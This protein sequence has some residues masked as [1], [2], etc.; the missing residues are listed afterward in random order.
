VR[1]LGRSYKAYL[2]VKAGL[3]AGWFTPPREWFTGLSDEAF[4]LVVRE[5]VWVAHLLFH[6]AWLAYAAALTKAPDAAPGIA[7][8][9]IRVAAEAARR[10]DWPLLDLGQ[11]FANTFLRE[12]VKR[13]DA[14]VVRDVARAY[15]DVL[16]RLC[17][18]GRAQAFQAVEKA[19]DHLRY[20][21]EFAW[22]TGASE[23][24]E[25][26]AGELSRVVELAAVEAPGSLPAVAAAFEDLRVPAGVDRRAL[27]RTA[28]EAPAL[29][30]EAFGF[31]AVE[32]LA[33]S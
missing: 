3:P 24:A 22:T 17:R 11:R 25:V 8:V 23:S 28:T 29:G 27:A 5:R 15:R 6:Q 31:E 18:A 19:A 20:Y 26:L 30:R 13:A 1:A 7:A 16:G 21:A 14:R 10:G 33:R 9:V 12:A 2:E 32:V 4:D